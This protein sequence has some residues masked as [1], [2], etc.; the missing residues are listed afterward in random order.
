MP[1]KMQT[2]EEKCGYSFSLNKEKNLPISQNNVGNL[3]KIQNQVFQKVAYYSKQARYLSSNDLE[4]IMSYKKNDIDRAITFLQ[5]SGFIKTTRANG[6]LYYCPFNE[7]K[8]L[9]KQK[10]DI[11]IN[12]KIESKIIERVRDAVQ[13]LYPDGLITTSEELTS[14]DGLRCFD[15]FFEFKLPVMSKQFI[16]VDVYTKIPV[17]EYIVQSFIRKIKWN[18]TETSSNEK[19]TEDKNYP[20]RGRTL[21]IIVCG[22]A[23]QKAVDAAHKYEI[24]LLSFRDIYINYDQIRKNI[25]I[26]G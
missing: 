13:Q 21:G 22:N 10:E 24:S 7:F 3:T 1:R 26:A 12:D 4:R 2:C 17:T 11:I 14:L 25:E 23:N 18:R 5:D 15:I 6:I 19:E 20:L 16:V 8:H 9:M